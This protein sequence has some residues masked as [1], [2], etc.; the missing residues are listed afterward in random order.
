VGLLHNEHFIPYIIL[1]KNINKSTA[2]EVRG[3]NKN[4]KNVQYSSVRGKAVVM[5]I[6]N[7]TTV[8]AKTK[9]NN[10]CL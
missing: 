7:G 2:M 1:S 8:V 4:Q 6:G 9:Q 10:Q 3:E 5:E